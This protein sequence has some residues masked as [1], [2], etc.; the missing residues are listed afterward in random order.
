M[1]EDGVR[2]RHQ[3]IR[4]RSIRR[5][6]ALQL[7]IPLLS[8]ILLY[9]FAVNDTLGA[10]LNKFQ[11]STVYD[12][13]VQPGGY[14]TTYLQLER[15]LTA[16]AVSSHG[17]A[18]RHD[19]TAQRAAT[20][21][22]IGGFLRSVRSPDLNGVVNA[23]VRQRLDDFTRRLSGL[24]AARRQI[25]AGR[26]DMLAAMQMFDDLIASSL[27]LYSGMSYINDFAVSRESEAVLL[28][29]WSWEYLLRENAL[30][31]AVLASPG[32]RIT[33]AEHHALVGWIALRRHYFAV[34]TASLSPKAGRPFMGLAAS[35][36][37]RQL[38]TAENDIS[39]TRVTTRLPASALRWQVASAPLMGTW[40]QAI[41]QAGT[42]IATQARRVGDRIVLRLVLV[43][44][45]GM[46]A[47]L[48]S[49]LFSVRFA[50]RFSRELGDLKQAVEDL[51]ER[52]LPLT[53]ARLRRGEEVD[54]GAHVPSRVPG[55]TTE[56]ERVADAFI[57]VHQTAIGSAVGEARLR[58]GISRV[59]VNLAWRSQS[60]LHRQLR[61]LDAMQRR[62]YSSE[63]LEQLFRLDHLTTRMRRNAEGLVI[64]SGAPAGRG[65]S[66]PVSLEDVLRAA[67]AEVED[68]TRVEVITS[69]S[70]LLAGPAVA[71]V[72]H[73]VA[74]L[75]ENATA[76][77]PPSS[78]VEVR[79]EIVGN[80]YA[81]EVVDQGIGLDPVE[82]AELNLRLAR[83]PD[84][85]LANSDRLGLFVVSTLAARHGIRV[86]LEPSVSRG[87]TV[88]TLIPQQLVASPGP[89]P[90]PDEDKAALPS[91][92]F[93]RAATGSEDQPD[94]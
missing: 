21:A 51:A 57:A 5:R 85:D 73:L 94:Q 40:R 54:P 62:T 61:M 64:L 11:T 56:I 89:D 84:F 86:T 82:R 90:S 78:Q 33:Q 45:A 49:I 72:I 50:R 36:G 76:F 42:G 8:V 15:A 74:E 35:A 46:V 77:S 66:Q 68:Y 9:A 88:V 71:D 81:I 31:G 80:G 93:R 67:A 1:T 32:A 10:A 53:V 22:A 79:G 83:V 58:N 92:R 41:V 12:K 17:Q 52:E 75:V 38:T 87:T 19:L 37:Y 14:V 24:P 16:V 70:A 44:G 91:A 29:G 18:G 30:T 48:L 25:D 13:I 65:W 55:R 27:R 34:S 39:G 28:M 7:V 23:P 20:D 2:G 69:S 59:F 47:V 43:G 4:T 26:T 6:I 60:L 3:R 63:D